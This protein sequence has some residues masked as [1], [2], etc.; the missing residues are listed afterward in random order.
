[1]QSARGFSQ[2]SDAMSVFK[3][4]LICAYVYAFIYLILIDFLAVHDMLDV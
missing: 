2:V 1:M 4:M 3:D